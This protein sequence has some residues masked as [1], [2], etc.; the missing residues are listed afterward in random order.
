MSNKVHG[1]VVQGA[2]DGG[3]SVT[4]D[5]GIQNSSVVLNCFL[6]IIFCFVHNNRPFVLTN[7]IQNAA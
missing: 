6:E 1:S 7:L 3:N 5:L 4:G 2:E